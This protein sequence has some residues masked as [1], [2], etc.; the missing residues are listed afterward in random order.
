MIKYLYTMEMLFKFLTKCN[1]GPK[2][3][4]LAIALKRAE[5]EFLELHYLTPE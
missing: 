1:Y 4:N 5:L 3:N 2:C